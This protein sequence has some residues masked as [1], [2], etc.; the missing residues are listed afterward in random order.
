MW[1]KTSW[2]TSAA[3]WGSAAAVAGAVAVS[4]A[5]AGVRAE[6]TFGAR[7]VAVATPSLASVTAGVQTASGSVG[8]VLEST[9]FIAAAAA[10]IGRATGFASGTAAA[11]SITSTTSLGAT[12]GARLDAA[13]SAMV[14][15]AR[16]VTLAPQLAAVS[17]SIATNYLAGT[18]AFRTESASATMAVAGQ[19][20]VSSAQVAIARATRTSTSVMGVV[21]SITNQAQ[22]TAATAILLGS[23]A[24]QLET[25]KAAIAFEAL[26]GRKGILVENAS[27]AML[28]DGSGT[29]LVAQTTSATANDARVGFSTA[30]AVK[31]D[32]ALGIM[33]TAAQAVAAATQ[34]E[35][36][37]VTT[38]FE[39]FT[40]PIGIVVENARAVTSAVGRATA[41]AAQATPVT[42]NDARVGLSV[43]NAVRTDTA[44]GTMATAEQ[45]ASAAAQLEAVRAITDF[46]NLEGSLG[47]IVGNVSAATFAVGSA[48]LPVAQATLITASDARIGLGATSAAR[49]DQAYG[50]MA[51]AAQGVAGAAQL[52]LI[53]ATTEFAEQG[54][55]PAFTVDTAR[56]AEVSASMAAA[57][58]PSISAA[59]GVDLFGSAPNQFVGLTDP[60]TALAV[61]ETSALNLQGLVEAAAQGAETSAGRAD[62][63]TSNVLNVVFVAD[64][65]PAGAETFVLISSAVWAAAFESYGAAQLSASTASARALAFYDPLRHVPAASFETA[66]VASLMSSTSMQAPAFVGTVKRRV[67]PILIGRTN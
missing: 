29:I 59:R 6:A 13:S 34:L 16:A 50:T 43:A 60:V 61:H 32:A 53:E 27:A 42:A 30:N 20:A 44:Q 19:A 14:Q 28:A 38:E 21:A 55:L 24:A 7:A 63:T 66:F 31:T 37:E 15:A 46:N 52:A 45:R 9:S 48:T 35:I 22:G 4:V 56:A 17:A 54:G 5:P 10:P 49:T 57:F 58:G 23:A 1:G 12:S 62:T 39:E 2:G 41:A 11:R 65:W 3:R 36:A 8:F 33:T 64:E 47:I 67:S 40:G 25:A 51:T 18:P 26:L